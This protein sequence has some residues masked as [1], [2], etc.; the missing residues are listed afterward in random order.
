M[1]ATGVA[2][3][4]G[5]VAG[6]AVLLWSPGAGADRVRGRSSVPGRSV[7]GSVRSHQDATDDDPGPLRRLK[8]AWRLLVHRVRGDRAA[9]W[10]HA[11]ELQVLDGLAAALEAGLPVSRAV[12]LAVDEAGQ[13]AA[14]AALGRT[15][16][17]GRPLGPAWERL[18]RQTASP[19]LRSVARAWR[20][21]ELTGAP[22]A[23]ALRVSTHAGRESHRLGRALQVAVA[24]PRA[25]VTVL[26]LLPLAGAGLAAVLGV[27]PSALYGHPLAQASVGAGAVL[28]L[29]GQVWVRGMVAK[30]L[31]GGG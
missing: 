4:I 19:T 20:V 26:T 5:A 28:L 31:R 15:A 1:T 9:R 25:T 23:G 2:L 13:E 11:A 29:I 17:E 12:R 10:A 24:G 16:A 18:A 3:A 6:T 22:L 30:V 21:A 27:G 8:V 14:W 7:T